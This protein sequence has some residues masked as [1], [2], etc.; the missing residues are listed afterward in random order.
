MRLISLFLLVPFSFLMAQMEENNSLAYIW[1]DTAIGIENSGLY[2]GKEYKENYKFKNG[3]HKFF[4][5]NGF[6]KGSVVYNDQPYYGILLK[7][8][9]FENE[10]LVKLPVEKGIAA[11]TLIKDEVA[12]FTIGNNRFIKI[13]LNSE[14]KGSSWEYQE[15]LLETPNFRFLKNHMA[16]KKTIKE[17]RWSYVEF[18]KKDTHSLF[19][20]ETY[21]PIRNK[22]DVI[23]IFPQYKKRLKDV[24][25]DFFTGAKRDENLIQL[26]KELNLDILLNDIA[27]DAE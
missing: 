25:R 23:E 10:L 7:L 3:K 19:Y 26:F 11:F 12:S 15:V 9:V 14:K 18:L 21:Y 13:P 1:F 24:S 27:K 17:E 2:L 5:F 8:D 6:Q 22:R 4:E 20:K 16:I